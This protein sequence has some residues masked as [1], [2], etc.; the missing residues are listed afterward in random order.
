M[1]FVSTIIHRIKWRIIRHRNGK[2]QAQHRRQLEQ[3]QLHPDQFL[4]FK[5]VFNFLNQRINKYLDTIQTPK[6]V[7]E[8][9]MIR[10]AYLQRSHFFNRDSRVDADRINALFVEA[11]QLEHSYVQQCLVDGKFS[12][13]LA[14]ALNEQIS[15]DE[16]VMVQSME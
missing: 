3:H 12:Q 13:S 15:T 7:N 5:E 14:N 11:F 1:S 2:V 9:T 16:L 8:I 6:N 10:R 4:S